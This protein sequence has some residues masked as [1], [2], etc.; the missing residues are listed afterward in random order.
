MDEARSGSE[1]MPENL[2]T[3]SE[4]MGRERSL[5]MPTFF[6]RSIVS[7]VVLFLSSAAMAQGAKPGSKESLYNGDRLKPE[8]T[9]GGPA[10]VRDVSGSWAG[11]LTPMRGAIP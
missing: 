3:Q 11:N 1:L 6:V 9:P 5:Q 4:F 10:P 2:G 7:L 8:S